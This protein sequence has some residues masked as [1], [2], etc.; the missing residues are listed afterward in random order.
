MKFLKYRFERK[1]FLASLLALFTHTVAADASG[2]YV[3]AGIGSADVDASGY[4]NSTAA[5]VFGGYNFT[6]NIGVEAA[7][8]DLGKFEVKGA[9]FPAG[10]T[11]N[12]LQVA[13]VGM[14]PMSNEFSFIG[15]LGAYSW[16]L[17]VNPCLSGCTSTD[18][19]AFAG[20]GVQ[21]MFTKNVGMR[22]EVEAF[23]DIG[24]ADII[25]L[26]AGIVGA[27]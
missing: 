15:K 20:V 4:N 27:F 16:T 7:Y 23:N 9:F 12:G 17:K 18:A 19:S 1:L 6:K 10:N 24:G 21:Y 11:V 13:V 25:S 5:K 26:T 2:F 14:L 3:G 22:G 8:A